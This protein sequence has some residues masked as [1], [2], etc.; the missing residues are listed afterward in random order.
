MGL[1]SLVSFAQASL[2]WTCSDGVAS[3]RRLLKII[4]L[5]CKRALQKRY[6]AKE[7]YDFREPTNRSHPIALIHH[8]RSHPIA[9]KSRNLEILFAKTT[10]FWKKT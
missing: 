5:F 8:D 10:C 2:L 4:G 6:S 7:T 9:A 3:I 1:F